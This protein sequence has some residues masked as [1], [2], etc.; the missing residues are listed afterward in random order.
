[1]E[2]ITKCPVLCKITHYNLLYFVNVKL[3]NDM[4][5]LIRCAITFLHVSD[6][7]KRKIFNAKG[8]T[9]IPISYLAFLALC[10]HYN[11]CKCGCDQT[12]IKGTLLKER[13][14]FITVT[15]LI[16]HGLFSHYTPFTHCTCATI[17]I[18]L[19]AIV[20]KEGH[21]IWW[22]KYLLHCISPTIPWT[23][24]KLHTY[25]SLRMR[26]SWY[27]FGCDRSLTKETL[28]SEQSTFSIVFRLLFYGAF[29]IYKPVTHCAC[30]TVGLSLVP[31]G[32]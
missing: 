26:Y 13:S 31:I 4:G 20:S 9:S 18:S 5:F 23:F 21:F 14:T 19:I 32:Q 25:H 1:M 2:N 10:V 11:W 8:L 30:S 12:K 6:L 22:T 27:K 17:G 15:R 24:L 7:S 28:F 3:C 16:F 29:S